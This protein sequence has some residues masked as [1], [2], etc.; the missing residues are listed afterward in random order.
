LALLVFLKAGW[1]MP[2]SN[3]IIHPFNLPNLSS[4]SNQFGKLAMS[5][6]EQMAMVFFP[7]SAKEACFLQMR[8]KV[9]YYFS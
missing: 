8:R 7:K 2:R 5:P 3:E 6:A 4:V 9:I 1:G